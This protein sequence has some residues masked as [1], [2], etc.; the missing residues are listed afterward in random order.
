ML[1]RTLLASRA[2]VML[3]V[4]LNYFFKDYSNLVGFLLLLNS[5]IFLLIAFAIYKRNKV[6]YYF[7]LAFVAL[8]ILLTIFDQM[9]LWDYLVLVLDIVIVYLI[10]KARQKNKAYMSKKNNNTLPSANEGQAIFAGGCFWGIEY[11]MQKADGVLETTVGYIGGD[12]D[13]PSYE[14]VC[15]HKTGHLEAVQ[16]IYDKGKTDFETLAK[17]FFEIHDPTQTDGQG[18]DKGEQYMSAIFYTDEKQKAVAEKLIDILKSKNYQI[19]TKLLPA[20]KFWPAEK[21]H[22]DYYQKKGSLPY[23]HSYQ[24]KFD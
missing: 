3:I 21:Y 4:S 7:S 12:K 15:A 1:L 16:V 24:K 19:I 23:C 18:T 8:D 11:Y 13:N 6:I 5:T 22:Q 10:F 20:N 17:L 9:G 2:L 14:E